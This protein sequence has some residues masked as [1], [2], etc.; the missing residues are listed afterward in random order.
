MTFCAEY[1]LNQEDN[2]NGIPGMLYGRYPGDS[3]AGGN[4]WQLLTAVTAKTLYQ[5]AT[6]MASANGFSKPEDQEAWAELLNMKSNS[7]T[8]EFIKASISAGDAIMY[9]MYQHV[10][11][12]GGHIA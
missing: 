1:P 12:D 6:T 4:P 11:D 3:Y 2:K 10:K 5:G 9:R 7:S 8:E